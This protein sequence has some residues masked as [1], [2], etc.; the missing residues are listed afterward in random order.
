LD[1]TLRSLRGEPA[2]RLKVGRLIGLD[3]LELY[4]RGADVVHGDI[5]TR[6][7]FRLRGQ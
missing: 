1:A 4:G 2:N 3:R 7:R 5:V 6:F